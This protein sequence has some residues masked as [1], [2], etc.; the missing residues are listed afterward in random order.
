MYLVQQTKSARP[1]A[2]CPEEVTS[3]RKEAALCGRNAFVATVRAFGNTHPVPS[4][5]RP[6]PTTSPSYNPVD[7]VCR[8][9]AMHGVVVSRGWLPGRVT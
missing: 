1:S 9:L 4:N 7:P 8:T 5:D 2:L 3:P 6:N